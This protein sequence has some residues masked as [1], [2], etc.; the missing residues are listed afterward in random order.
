MRL[1]NLKR[2][3]NNFHSTEI[4]FVAPKLRLKV[5]KKIVIC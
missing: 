3:K 1:H 2:S 4:R 5:S